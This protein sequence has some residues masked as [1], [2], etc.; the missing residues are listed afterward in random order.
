MFVTKKLQGGIKM[1]LKKKLF[2]YLGLLSMSI[3]V[4]SGCSEEEAD[5]NGSANKIEAKEVFEFDINNWASSTHH[6][7]YNVY[8]PWKEFVEEKTRKSVKVNL[9]HG[10]H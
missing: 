6:Y 10:V 1:I 3:L 8:E 7:A 9:Y 4:L 2:T 5:T